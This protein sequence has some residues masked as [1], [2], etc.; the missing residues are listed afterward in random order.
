MGILT[1]LQFVSENQPYIVPSRNQK[2]VVTNV[3]N[4]LCLYQ[5]QNSFFQNTI[6]NTF[7]GVNPK[8]Q[9]IFT[10]TAT[11]Q[12]TLEILPNQQFNV[13]TVVCGQKLYLNLRKRCIV[14]CP[15]KNKRPWSTSS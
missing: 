14:L 12:W 1:T 7:L 5:F 13:S 3:Q 9:V 8:R 10:L 15:Q 11:T 6:T 2:A 4:E